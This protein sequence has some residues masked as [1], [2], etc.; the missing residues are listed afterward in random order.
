M[1]RDAWSTS[2]TMKGGVDG[3]EDGDEDGDEDGGVGGGVGGGVE[4]AAVQRV[5]VKHLRTCSVRGHA[6]GASAG[7]SS[8]R[9][10]RNSATSK[11][12]PPAPTMATAWGVII[13]AS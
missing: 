13:T 11:P 9:W 8:A 4:R 7:A 5:C 12:M 2:E 1:V 10:S 3:G 6:T